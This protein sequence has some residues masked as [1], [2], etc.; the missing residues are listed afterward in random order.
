VEPIAVVSRRR[1]RQYLDRSHGAT[2]SAE[3][4]RGLRIGEMAWRDEGLDSDFTVASLVA[5]T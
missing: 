1:R 4:S 5:A 2:L 3:K